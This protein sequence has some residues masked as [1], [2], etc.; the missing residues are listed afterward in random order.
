ML[1]IH[2]IKSFFMLWGF[3]LLIFVSNV[4]YL[5]S[6]EKVLNPL[7]SF[8]L[9]D[10][11]SDNDFSIA[12]LK[13]DKKLLISFWASWCSNCKHELKV[14][15][16]QLEARKDL[17]VQVVSINIDQDPER[18]KHFIKKNQIIVPVLKDQQGNFIK[19]LN[20]VNVPHWAIYCFK[21]QKWSL[22]SHQEGFD[23]PKVEEQLRL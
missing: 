2:V 5:E 21:D 15:L 4:N 16:P 3:F 10:L 20:V 17:N 9:V 6:V 22:L 11:T 14:L 1:K 19:E 7:D 18:A 13:R 8:K 23:L 12:S